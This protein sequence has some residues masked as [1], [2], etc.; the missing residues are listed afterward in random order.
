[1]N[2]QGQISSMSFSYNQQYAL[3]VISDTGDDQSSNQS[4]SPFSTPSISPYGSPPHASFQYS[5]SIPASNRKFATVEF[6]SQLPAPIARPIKSK[7]HF[8]NSISAKANI[9]Q[10]RAINFPKRS[11]QVNI[12]EFINSK[13][14]S[15][16]AKM[17]TFCKSNGESEFIYTSHSLKNSVNKITCPVLLKYTCVECGASGENTHTIKY[18]PVMQKKLRHQMLNKIVV[19]NAN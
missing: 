16:R 9:G 11:E 19:S 6:V 15:S 2:Y 4:W 17:C 14:T 10:E 5:A 12:T 7:H 3:T 18:C 8:D 1:M 13:T